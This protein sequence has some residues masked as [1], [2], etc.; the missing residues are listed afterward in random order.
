ML[1]TV[2]YMGPTR[3][4]MN[5]RR[6]FENRGISASKDLNNQVEI[7]D[8]SKVHRTVRSC[9][10]PIEDLYQLGGRGPVGEVR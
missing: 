4:T 7:D 5:Y 3:Q 10:G 1:Q 2:D 9:G 8:L 6:S